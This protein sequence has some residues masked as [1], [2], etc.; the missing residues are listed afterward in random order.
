M[1]KKQPLSVSTLIMCLVL[2]LACGI[3][4]CTGAA[5]IQKG[6]YIFFLFSTGFYVCATM[7]N[8]NFETKPQKLNIYFNSSIFIKDVRWT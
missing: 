3:F 2:V 5:A 4:A 8:T 6:I 1:N 7:C